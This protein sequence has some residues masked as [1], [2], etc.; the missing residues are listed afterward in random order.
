MFYDRGKHTEFLSLTTE[1][2]GPGVLEEGKA[3]FPF[4]FLNVDKSNE[5]YTGLNVRL[6]LGFL[7]GLKMLN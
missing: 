4:L 6:R 2:S 1:L 7:K 3:T 5:S